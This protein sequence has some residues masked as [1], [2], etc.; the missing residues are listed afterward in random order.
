[1]TYWNKQ[2]PKTGRLLPT[3]PKIRFWYNVKVTDTCWLWTGSCNPAG[4][5]QFCVAGKRLNVHRYAYE[6]LIGPIPKGYT[7]DHVWANG[8]RNKNCVKP[9]H[10]EAVTIKVNVQRWAQSLETCK[11][12][13]PWTTE[14][15]YYYPTTG[16]RTC[17]ICRR[18]TNNKTQRARYERWR[19][20]KR[21]NAV[22]LSG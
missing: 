13:H 17:I 10:L 2:D 12:G 21:A 22:S 3:D 16:K 9:A 19:D 4:Y 11:Q 1:M 5:G 8:C 6:L 18:I 7:I 15:T 14:S 20:K